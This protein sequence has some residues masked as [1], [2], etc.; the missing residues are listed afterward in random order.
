MI[1]M[2][3]QVSQE[4]AAALKRR[5]RARNVSVA[6]VVRDAIDR[7][8]NGT[9]DRAAAW[10]RAWSAV[11]RFR[12]DGANVAEEHDRYLVDAYLQTKQ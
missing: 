12:G 6:A 9:D 2:Q 1:R 8:L 10:T 7:E 11:G 3:I 5:A 4:Q